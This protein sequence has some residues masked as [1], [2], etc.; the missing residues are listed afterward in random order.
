[1]TREPLDERYAALFAA[2]RREPAP[3]ATRQR[4]AA[5]LR[6]QPRRAT[7]AESRRRPRL[8]GS[9]PFMVAAAALVAAVMLWMRAPADPVYITAEAPKPTIAKKADT[10]KKAS[11]ENASGEKAVAPVPAPPVTT[12]QRSAHRA[13][14]RAPV[15]LEQEL[16]SMQRAR[17]ALG[18]GDAPAALAELDEFARSY[19]WRRLAVEASLLRIE[20][21]AQ[22]GRADEARDLAHRFVEQNPNNPLVDRART[23]AAPPSPSGVAG[24]TKGK[25]E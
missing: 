15:S 7:V 6:A 8:R 16:A 23:F 2:A 3:E 4:I 11:E 19:G 13:R 12:P 1:M 9:L 22:A 24:P 5:A 21:L 14:A 25:Q 18:R 17:T 10:D 20:A